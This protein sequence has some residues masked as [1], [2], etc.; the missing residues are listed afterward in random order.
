[1]IF[2]DGVVTLGLPDRALETTDPLS[3]KHFRVSCPALLVNLESSY[4]LTHIIVL[5]VSGKDVSAESFRSTFTHFEMFEPPTQCH[6]HLH[7]IGVEEMISHM[8]ILKH[9]KYIQRYLPG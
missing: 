3:A 9:E 2:T 1:M 6:T 4:D 8:D 5:K 7:R